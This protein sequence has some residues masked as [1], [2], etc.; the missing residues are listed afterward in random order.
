MTCEGCKEGCQD[1]YPWRCEECGADDP[2]C[3]D[4]MMLHLCD[5]C[6]ESQRKHAAHDNRHAR[7]CR[8][9]QCDAHSDPPDY[10]DDK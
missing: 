1:C 7:Y 6:A 9:P 5:E 10:R 4:D 2:K 3:Q 8:D